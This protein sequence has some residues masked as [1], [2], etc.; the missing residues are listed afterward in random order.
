M[1]S[2]RFEGAAEA[3]RDRAIGIRAAEEVRK[4]RQKVMVK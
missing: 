1:K 4:E 3:R 2:E